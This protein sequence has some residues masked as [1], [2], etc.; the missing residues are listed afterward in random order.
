M[1]P[2]TPTPDVQS[3]SSRE[4]LLGITGLIV[5]VVG[6]GIF[7]VYGMPFFFTSGKLA[8]DVTQ[9]A[10]SSMPTIVNTRLLADS[11]TGTDK[12]YIL[13][14]SKV[15]AVYTSMYNAV[16]NATIALETSYKNDLNPL[17]LRAQTAAK[18]KDFQSLTSIGEEAKAVNDAQK[19]R[20][21]TLSTNLANLAAAAKTLTDQKTILLTNDS[22]AAGKNFVAKYTALSVLI[23]AII[24]G[25]VSAQTVTQA[26]TISSE[27][28]LATKSFFDANKKL[29]DYFVD[30]IV[31]DANAL[32]SAQTAPGQ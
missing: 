26:K 10:A 5:L 13:P 18:N 27:I 11:S 7:Y 1:P 4:I 31:S 21:A 30:T 19:V 9:K 17:L 23:D 25:N 12:K 2:T 29:S 22:V 32:L 15:N 14:S 8:I 24:S 16:A 6:T 28:S 20:L 3:T